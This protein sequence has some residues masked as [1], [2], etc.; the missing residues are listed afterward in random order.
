MM[1]FQPGGI[2]GIIL[3]VLD[4]WAIIKIAQSRAEPL[5]K[6]IWIVIVIALPFLGLIIW[7]FFGPK[8]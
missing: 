4:I 2:F 7:F 1:D 5:W 3:L 8:G 6:A